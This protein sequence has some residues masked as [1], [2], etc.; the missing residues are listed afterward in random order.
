M[1]TIRQRVPVVDGRLE[2][3]DPALRGVT[4]AEVVVTVPEPA[5]DDPPPDREAQTPTAEEEGA[6]PPPPP[7]TEMIG[8]AKGLFETPE[9]VDAYIRALRNEWD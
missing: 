3:S 9:E 1:P 5:G 7:L 8:A 6:L 4:E 2:V